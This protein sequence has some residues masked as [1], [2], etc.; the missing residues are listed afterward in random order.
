[1]KFAIGDL[2]GVNPVEMFGNISVDRTLIGIGFDEADP[3]FVIPWMLQIQKCP[4]KPRPD[5][6]LLF[7]RVLVH[8]KGNIAARHIQNLVRNLDHV[9][10]SVAD[11]NAI[12]TAAN[13]HII[14]DMVRVTDGSEV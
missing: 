4:A 14:A 5:A 11:H 13:R 9:Q 2:V 3:E 1:M 8:I 10:P 7:M 6:I 12:E